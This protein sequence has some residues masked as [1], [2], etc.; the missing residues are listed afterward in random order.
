MLQGGPFSRMERRE[1]FQTLLQ[2]TALAANNSALND[3]INIT[4]CHTSDFERTRLNQIAAVVLAKMT[5]FMGNQAQNDF[6]WYA[7]KRFTRLSEY[8]SNARRLKLMMVNARGKFNNIGEIQYRL[9][10]ASNISPHLISRFVNLQSDKDFLTELS[11]LEH[12]VV[13]M[14]MNFVWYWSIFSSPTFLSLVF[15]RF[16]FFNSF[17]L[18][19]S[20]FVV[21]LI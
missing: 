5:Q 14:K 15:S 2:G 8:Q 21:L 17:V 20:V 4:Y 12:A 10:W 1:I 3:L 19:C 16:F 9:S 13:R 6:V 18:L 7:W 11:R